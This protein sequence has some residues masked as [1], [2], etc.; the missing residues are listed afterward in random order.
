V[1]PAWSV[2][3]G[4]AASII[5]A[6]VMKWISDD[7]VLAFLT[8]AV[9]G[10]LGAGAATVAQ[11][12]SST[13]ATGRGKTFGLIAL[14]TIFLL[15]TTAIATHKWGPKREFRDNVQSRFELRIREA[16][17]RS[18]NG[19]TEKTGFSELHV[20]GTVSG[21]GSAETIW[22][23]TLPQGTVS[24]NMTEAGLEDAEVWP[25]FGPCTVTGESWTC[26]RVFLP[27]NEKHYILAYRVNSS[28]ARF[29]VDYQIGAYS[30]PLEKCR[31]SKD[32]CKAEPEFS[33]KKLPRGAD[34]V[35]HIEKT[36]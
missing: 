35:A 16:E 1:S 30:L 22:L 5:S 36:L 24:Q 29:F 9:F 33:P 15:C 28:A 23:A 32:Q 31:T 11:L 4:T 26:D 7:W 2:L 34:L 19:D 25:V 14:T 13:S 6:V 8:L 3:T 20:T 18:P 10:V 27:P 12:R 17:K 21:L